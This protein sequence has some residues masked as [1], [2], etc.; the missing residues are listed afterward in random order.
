VIAILGGLG[1]AVLWASATLTSSRAGRL[2]GASSTLAWMMLV[3]LVVAIPL[4]VA[5][6]PLPTLTPSTT[7]WMLC[8]GIG[9]VVGLLFV[10][11]GLRI[12][13]VGVIAALASTEG[14]IAAVISVVA[15][16]RMTI[17]V[18]LTLCVIVVGIAVVALASG[19]A[20]ETDADGPDSSAGAIPASAG[21]PARH[22]FK[23][24]QRAVLWGVAAALVFGLSIYSTAR[25]GASM[26]PMMAVLPARVVGVVGVFIPLAVAG[27]LRLT[28]PAAPMVLLI[29][30]GEVFGN[31]SFV[32]GSGQ[33]IAISAVLA[34]QFAAISAVA[35]F[36]LFHERL[37]LSQR[38]GVIAIAVGV[39]VL[40]ATRG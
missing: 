2:I 29:G 14:A 17:P 35:A 9:N 27:R 22:R 24:A 38:Y 18:A 1:A 20:E 6:G 5:S 12:G 32:V 30:L 25:L 16:E 40:T 3:G 15:G 23:P 37:S 13:K 31:A 28:R 11:R 39:A 26:S 36:V 33:S 19:E 34:S 10:Y 21:H 4:G 7:V 8:S